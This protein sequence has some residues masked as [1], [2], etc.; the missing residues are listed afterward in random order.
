MF[1]VLWGCS[2]KAEPVKSLAQKY[3]ET[4]VGRAA[5]TLAEEKAEPP[6][7]FYPFAAKRD[8]F[9][10]L[11]GITSG[12]ND[13]ASGKGLAK[14]ELSNL[15]LKGIMLDR[16]GKVAY[17][18]STTGEVFFLRSGR[19]YDK[20]NRVVAGVSGI[21]KENSVVLISQNRTMTELIMQ[22]KHDGT[23][24]S[25]TA[26]MSAPAQNAPSSSR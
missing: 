8:P 24:A 15:E 22:K 6:K 16:K 2:K 5:E 18:A 9:A 7:Y 11:V 14:G 3:P 4:V 10:P 12:T 17:I 21:I 13:P 20:K 23:S 25:M 1:C 19:I 26:P